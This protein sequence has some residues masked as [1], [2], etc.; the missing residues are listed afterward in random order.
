MYGYYRLFRYPWNPGHIVG[1]LLVAV[2]IPG[3]QEHPRLLVYPWYP[4]IIVGSLL[5]S[6][7]GMVTP[8]WRE[9]HLV[10]MPSLPSRSLLVPGL[11]NLH[12]NSKALH[13]VFCLYICLKLFLETQM[14]QRYPLLHLKKVPKDFDNMQIPTSTLKTYRVEGILP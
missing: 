7:S 11:K 3:C 9:A 1:N 8:D 14:V 5:V 10:L 12:S 13:A 6:L 4:C 2:P